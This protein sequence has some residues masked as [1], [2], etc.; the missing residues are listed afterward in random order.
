MES[1]KTST[2][3]DLKAI[4]KTELLAAFNGLLEDI[5]EE[6][7]LNEDQL[8]FLNNE[9]TLFILEDLKQE[10]LFLNLKN[11]DKNIIDEKTILIVIE[12]I[13]N[14][15]NAK[16]ILFAP[17]TSNKTVADTLV[18]L[19]SRL[20]QSSVIAPPTKRDYSLDKSTTPP[21]QPRA[22]DSYRE[23]VDL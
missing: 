18:N 11:I 6:L 5:K 2:S 21:A 23:K 10:N 14:I 13:T 7:K 22:T 19:G 12:K 16:D 3:T 20:S 4:E 9:I 8:F 17:D 15:L 1:T